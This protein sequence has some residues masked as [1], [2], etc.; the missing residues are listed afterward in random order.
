MYRI[1]PYSR[2]G[3]RDMTLGGAANGYQLQE[4]NDCLDIDV[5]NV[6]RGGGEEGGVA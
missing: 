5:R 3:R 1:T 2:A 4:V 6:S